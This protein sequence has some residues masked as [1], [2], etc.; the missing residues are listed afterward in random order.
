MNAWSDREVELVVADY[1]DML[2]K[3][4]SGQF[5]KKSGH[6][7]KL[8]P[9][10]NKR[11]EG[12]V[13]FKH[14]N[15]SAVLIRLG[16]PYISGYLPRFNYQHMLERAVIDYLAQDPSMEDQFRRFAEE[17]I[18]FAAPGLKDFS[19]L[20]VEA[21]LAG[22]RVEEPEAI[23]SRNPIKINYLE[24]EQR[25]RK[26]GAFGEEMV[27]AYEKWYLTV[28]GKE[29]LADQVRWIAKEEGDGAGF[30]ILSRNP[31]GTDKYI[32]VKT[33]RLGKETPF[34]FSRNEW[35]FSRKKQ[36]DYHLYRLFNFA[37]T[38]KMFVKTGGLD[39]VCTSVPVMF[40]GYF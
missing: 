31:D 25:N 29:N 22:S 4:L 32:E 24:A 19:K 21:P 10:L 6:R 7:E 14:Q 16:Q 15:I 17:E 37:R 36:E 40:K 34:F 12:A 1:F 13:E 33:T 9:L 30:D 26:L 20:I 18:L 8:L 39:T 23:Y 11:S 5:Y 38:A 28:A 27:L 2:S 35:L 3:D